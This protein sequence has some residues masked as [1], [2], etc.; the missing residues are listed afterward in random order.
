ML[1]LLTPE[2]L[3]SLSATC[4]S[5]R[6]S[7]CAKVT[8]I[9]VSNLCCKA[10]PHLSIVVCEAEPWLNTNLHLKL[11]DQW[12]YMMEME[13]ALGAVVLIRSRQ[14]SQIPLS[15]LPSQHLVALSRFTDKVRHSAVCIVLRGPLVLCWII[16]SFVHNS[17]SKLLAISV[18]DS[19]PD[20]FVLL[21]LGRACPH[22]IQLR[23]WNNQLDTNTISA[24]KPVTWSHLI[25][26]YLNC[27]VLGVAG[28][29]C[30]VSCS[31]PSLQ[32]FGLEYTSI[33]GPA[34]QTTTA[35]ARLCSKGVTHH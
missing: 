2:A 7:F 35:A 21:T 26:L 1:E 16:W 23:L 24:M 22:L 8:I 33:D 5:L 14:Q 28:V 17:W 18:Q 29:R 6:T 32:A 4:K 12:E 27:N 13:V 10:W 25:D 19:C 15:D 20:L 30:I 11:S 34:V 31:L 9:T 3:W